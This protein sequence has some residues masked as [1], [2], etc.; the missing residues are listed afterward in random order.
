MQVACGHIGTD[1]DALS[2]R[3]GTGVEPLVHA[4]DHHRGFG[5][6]FDDRVVDR[7]GA[8]PAR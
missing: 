4:H 1:R 8:A 7:G 2:H 5:I 6:A 3:D